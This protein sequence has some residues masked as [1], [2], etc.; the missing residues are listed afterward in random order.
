[1]HGLKLLIKEAGLVM[2]LMSAKSEKTLLW[3]FSDT[4]C[5]FL[6]ITLY[7]AVIYYATSF[8]CI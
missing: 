5:L 8:F 3:I 6:K 4:I 1:M 7:L 2:N